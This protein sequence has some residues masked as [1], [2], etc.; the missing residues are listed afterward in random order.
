VASIGLGARPAS[1]EWFADVFAGLSFTQSDDLKLDDRG[2]GQGVFEDVQFDKSLSWGGRAGRYF[3]SVPFLGLGVDFFRFSSSA[4]SPSS[5]AAVSRA[6]AAP[7]GAA[8]G[9]SVVSQ[10]K[11]TAPLSNERGSINGVS[12]VASVINRRS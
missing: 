5:S 12:L 11:R 7:G 3:D 9:P 10:A 6:A 2:V 1:A 4:R 8:P